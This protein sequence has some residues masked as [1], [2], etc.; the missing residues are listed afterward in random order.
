MSNTPETDAVKHCDYP[1]I[2]A[3][4]CKLERE[5][6]QLK[7]ELQ[8]AHMQIDLDKKPDGQLALLTAIEF[9]FRSCEKGNNLEKTLQD[10]AKL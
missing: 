4:C 5:R 2:L 9:G 1:T 3:T 10:F 6:D 7:R 8:A